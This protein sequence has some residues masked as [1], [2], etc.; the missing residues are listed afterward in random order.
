MLT[1]YCILDLE[2]IAAPDCERW[3]SP[4]EADKRL[5]DPVKIANDIA[6]KRQAQLDAAAIDADLCQIVMVGMELWNSGPTVLTILTDDDERKA[7]ERVWQTLS[8]T[9]PMLGYGVSFY[10]AGVL[11]RR[12]QLLGVRVPEKF[13]HFGKYHHDWIVDLADRFTLNGRIEQKKGRGLD[14]HCQRLGI[15]VED[16]VSGADVAGLWATNEVE[17]IRKHCLADL[18]RI[19]LLAERLGVIAPV[20]TEDVTVQESGVF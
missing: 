14:Y 1:R 2:T 17:L 8:A 19:R 9:C 16:S 11:V 15:E 10:D 4:F 13:Y 12:S 7:L 6:N 18:M 20:N 5:T 3:L